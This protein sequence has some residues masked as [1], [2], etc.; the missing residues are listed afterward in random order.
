MAVIPGKFGATLAQRRLLWAP[1]YSSKLSIL[2]ATGL[3]IPMG[4]LQSEAADVTTVTTRG[5]LQAVF[6]YSK[7]RDGFDTP[8]TVLGPSRIPIIKFDGVDEE[9]DSPDAAYWSRVAGA[10]SVGA[11]INMVDAT[12]SAIL[13]KYDAAGDTRE[14]IFGLTSGDDLQLRCHDQD[15]VASASI[16]T[17]ADVSIVEGSWV[18]AVGTYDGSANAS[19]INLYQDGAIIAS[20]DTDDAN[21]LNLEDLGG[22]VKLAHL[23]A[24]PANLFDGSMAGGPLGPFFVQTALTADQILRLYQLEREALGV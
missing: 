11:W 18:F 12:S 2:G 5:E 8:A 19:G 10:F 1:Y 3:I 20:S 13:T 14:W 22:T 6:T 21:F 9:A 4:D 24:T 16:D 15:A 23:N 7:A 17:T